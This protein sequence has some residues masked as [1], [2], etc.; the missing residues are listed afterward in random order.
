MPYDDYDIDQLTGKVSRATAE[1]TILKQ[2]FQQV[3]YNQQSI[4]LFAQQLAQLMEDTTKSTSTINKDMKQWVLGAQRVSKQLGHINREAFLHET[5]MTRLRKGYNQLG[6][7]GKSFLKTVNFKDHFNVAGSQLTKFKGLFLGS[8]KAMGNLQINVARNISQ[9]GRH[10][11]QDLSSDLRSMDDQILSISQRLQKMATQQQIS[12]LPQKQRRGMIEVQQHMIDAMQERVKLLVD[13]RDGMYDLIQTQSLLNQKL[14]PVMNGVDKIAIGTDRVGSGIRNLSSGLSDL[15]IQIIGLTQFADKMD[16]DKPVQKLKKIISQRTFQEAISFKNVKKDGAINFKELGKSII[17]IMSGVAKAMKVILLGAFTGI[18]L[19]VAAMMI[20]AFKKMWDYNQQRQ[21]S[22]IS[23][24][25][26]ASV[27]SGGRGMFG[28]VYAAMGGHQWGGQDASDIYENMRR[29][30][31]QLPTIA[32]NVRRLQ[33]TFSVTTSDAAKLLFNLKEVGG[34]TQQSASQFTIRLGKMAQHYGYKSADVLSQMANLSQDVM[35]YFAGVQQKFIR[36]TFFA[37]RLNLTVQQMARTAEG[38][39]DIQDTI[40]K[41][42]QLQLLTGQKINTQ[43]LLHYTNTGKIQEANALIIDT[44]IK[45]TDKLSHNAML[46]LSETTGFSVGQIKQ[47][48]KQL[49]GSQKTA[50]QI[51]AQIGREAQDAKDP[52]TELGKQ[53]RGLAVAAAPMKTQMDTLNT[54]IKETFHKAF[55]PGVESIQRVIMQGKILDFVQKLA[56]W[57]GNITNKFLNWITLPGTIRKIEGTLK[58]VFNSVKWFYQKLVVPIAKSFKWAHDKGGIAGVL[59]LTA[60]YAILLNIGKVIRGIVTT[61]KFIKTIKGVSSGVGIAQQVAQ[62]TLGS[63]G[64]YYMKGRSGALAGNV[65]QSMLKSGTAKMAG[66]AGIG[67]GVVGAASVASVGMLGKVFAGVGK[68]VSVVIGGIKAFGAALVAL[69]PIAWAVVAVVAALTAGFLIWRKHVRDNDPY[70]QAMKG[71][72]K[73]KVGLQSTIKTTQH[74]IDTKQ[75]H[76][77]HLTNALSTYEQLVKVQGRSVIQ[78]KRLQYAIRDLIGQKQA[79]LVISGKMELSQQ[80]LMKVKKDMQDIQLQL[81]QL[82]RKNHKARM[83]MSILQMRQQ[84]KKLALKKADGTWF[85]RWFGGSAGGDF[86]RDYGKRVTNINKLVGM[87][88]LDKALIAIKTLK[89]NPDFMDKFNKLNITQ[90]LEVQSIFTHAQMTAGEVGL[91]ESMYKET[92]FATGGVVTRPTRALIGEAGAQAVI[93]LKDS[94]FSSLAQ[95]ITDKMQQTEGLGQLTKLIQKLGNRPVHVTI[96]M[97]GKRVG[98]AIANNAMFT[99][100]IA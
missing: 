34:M 100:G 15:G 35:I 44:Y 64:R 90:Q 23:A 82:Q 4:T 46:K 11:F 86:G 57:L 14:Q 13:S 39:S 3:N 42:L 18:A 88:Q 8:F 25:K 78:N 43:Q 50:S 47:I 22:F 98:K 29:F 37:R 33:R 62:L 30:G 32:R 56:G 24:Q 91:Y 96:Q 87:G 72:Q 81:M 36:S 28:S 51:L 68:A 60:G 93:P 97:D 52:M 71:L 26:S 7:V 85:T 99:P 84:T 16:M 65:A 6:I 5:N 53:I 9:L 70:L 66:Q 54:R 41:T 2:V 55:L 20:G 19:S 74:A 67:Q 80:Q 45:G 77:D 92:P 38:F 27:V 63:T 89:S 49:K 61:V 75:R 10:G 12:L 94:V 48:Q 17:S 79:E 73:Y 21:S 95:N 1:A 76:H 83:R 31:D 59:G 69:N 40:Q 58:A